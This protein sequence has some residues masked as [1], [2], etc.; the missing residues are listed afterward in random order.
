MHK[1]KQKYDQDCGFCCLMMLLA[2]IS[3]DRKYD[4]VIS[5][6]QNKA[7][8][9]KELI[10]I[11][12]QYGLVMEGYR[13][14]ILDIPSVRLP[15]IMSIQDKTNTHSFYAYKRKGKRL[16]CIDPKDGRKVVISFRKLRDKGVL[17]LII[18]GNPLVKPQNKIKEV[19]FK[20][21]IQMIVLWLLET[22]NVLSLASLFLTLFPSG[23]VLLSLGLLGLSLLFSLITR[24]CL[25]QYLEHFDKNFTHKYIKTSEDKRSFYEVC[26]KAKTEIFISKSTLI[27]SLSTAVILILA[28]ASFSLFSLVIPSFLITFTF[29]RFISKDPLKKLLVEKM[30]FYEQEMLAKN[31][32]HFEYSVKKLRITTQLMYLYLMVEKILPFL[33]VG[34]YLLIS[35]LIAKQ[36]DLTFAAIIICATGIL[37]SKLNDALRIVQNGKTN[38]NTVLLT[39]S[40]NDIESSK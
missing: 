33:V 9:L 28:F 1:I 4:L 25:Y 3:N 29:L 24:L 5:S 8:S 17:F 11:A 7:L 27:T 32:E 30:Y 23:S 40:I 37:S 13:V 15:A 20:S 18:V 6:S 31:N 34:L 38:K 10:V 21:N 2:N 12:Q 39:N 35:F 22:L 26:Q 19:K 16:F 14:E 36:F